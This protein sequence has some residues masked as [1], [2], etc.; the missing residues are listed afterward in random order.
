MLF[1][2]PSEKSFLRLRTVTITSIKP[3]Q[4]QQQSRSHAT[5]IQWHRIFITITKER[6]GCL[7]MKH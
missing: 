2:N 6:K 1:K 4:Q 5:N 7:V 3:K